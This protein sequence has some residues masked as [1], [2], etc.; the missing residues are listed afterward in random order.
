ML[1][2]RHQN[3]ISQY[4]KKWQNGVNKEASA[5]YGN[6]T[7]DNLLQDRPP[8]CFLLSLASS[9]PFF[10]PQHFPL[11]FFSSPAVLFL[12]L[13]WCLLSQ[14]TLLLS[15]SPVSKHGLPNHPLQLHASCR[16]P[17]ALS[18]VPTFKG[19][20]QNGFLKMH[21]PKNSIIKLK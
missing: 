16:R 17:P 13:S 2:F 7:W 5:T 3:S 1:T 18:W 21:L 15:Y 12:F 4:P 6:D 19:G 20:L 10:L 14:A 9:L 11:V 8:A